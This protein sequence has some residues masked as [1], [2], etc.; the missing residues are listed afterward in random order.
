MLTSIL[1]CKTLHPRETLVIQR[2]TKFM[3]ILTE[4]TYLLKQLLK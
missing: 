3:E 4:E 2:E 1:K